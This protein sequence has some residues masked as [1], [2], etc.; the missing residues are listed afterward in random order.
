MSPSAGAASS[1]STSSASTSSAWLSAGGG[2]TGVVFSGSWWADTALGCWLLLVPRAGEE[3]LAVE[4]S[5]ASVSGGIESG[6]NR[7]STVGGEWGLFGGVS[8]WGSLAAVVSLGLLDTSSVLAASGLVVLGVFLSSLGAHVSW[9]PSGGAHVSLLLVAIE[10]SSGPVLALVSDVSERFASW[11]STVG[12]GWV[13]LGCFSARGDL[14]AEEL[15]SAASVSSVE[16]LLAGWASTSAWGWVL[17]GD[18]LSA[19]LSLLASHALHT[20]IS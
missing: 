2:S 3:F 20:E 7:A 13:F 17:L 18:L 10:I 14:L 6:S 8:A 4:S 19:H 11:A 16:C 9:A 1:A 12:L 5:C 15:S